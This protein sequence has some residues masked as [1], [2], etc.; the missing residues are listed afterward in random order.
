LSFVIARCP[1][2][3]SLR[4]LRALGV[5]TVNL[6]AEIIYRRDAEHAEVT[7]RNHANSA[8]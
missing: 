7:Q 3:N 8:T 1:E 4:Q 2:F 6:D 5:S